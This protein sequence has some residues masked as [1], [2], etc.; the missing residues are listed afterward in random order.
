MNF[1]QYFIDLNHIWRLY[2]LMVIRV[3]FYIDTDLATL[4][5]Q[6]GFLLLRKNTMTQKQ[7]GDERIYMA[8]T[9]ILLFIT[10]GSQDKNSSRAG[11]GGRNWCRGC[12]GM[13]L[14]GLLPLAVLVHLFIEPRT[15]ITQGWYHPSWGRPSSINNCVTVGSLGG[16]FQSDD[17]RLYEVDKQN[18]LL[19]W[20][21]AQFFIVSL[22]HLP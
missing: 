3:I 20:S 17:S 15:S 16:S 18:H 10:E 13:L 2:S 19:H 21:T 5:S 22:F 12:G 1:I 14:T 7:V 9:S 6:L 11:F 4:I 8:Y